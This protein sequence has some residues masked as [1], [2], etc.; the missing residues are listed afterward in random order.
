MDRALQ[1][2]ALAITVL[3]LLSTAA[4]LLRTREVR[5]PVGVLLD[6]LLAAGLLRL[7]ASPTPTAIASAALIV[8]IRRVVS[9]GL[10]QRS[11]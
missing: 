4:V 9:F 6:F 5:L 10:A 1:T 8:L 2:A 3:G 7:S 11:R